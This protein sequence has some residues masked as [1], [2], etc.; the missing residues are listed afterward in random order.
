MF[1]LFL[2]PLL[3]GLGPIVGTRG[4]SIPFSK[5]RATPVFMIV[6]AREMINPL[7]VGSHTLP[8]NEPP[9]GAL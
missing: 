8:T 6:R 7:F 3:A 1:G 4:W 5:R 9:L 2:C